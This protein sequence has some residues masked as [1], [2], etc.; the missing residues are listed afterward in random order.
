MVFLLPKLEINATVYTI[1][2][3]K[4]CLFDLIK[5]LFNFLKNSITIQESF[6][7][8]F[9]LLLLLL[10]IL[11]IIIFSFKL[12]VILLFFLHF[13]VKFITF[14]RVVKSNDDVEKQEIYDGQIVH[15]LF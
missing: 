14:I 5:I 3:T 4:I 6:H 12:F 2:T 10:E 1:N 7:F 13:F 9:L 8:L 11:L 15:C